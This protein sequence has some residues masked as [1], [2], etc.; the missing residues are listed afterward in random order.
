MRVILN[1]IWFAFAGLWLAITY[2]LAA[3]PPPRRRA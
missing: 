2:L 3:Q 1:V